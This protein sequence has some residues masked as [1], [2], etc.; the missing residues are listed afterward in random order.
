MINLGL[1]SDQNVYY[2]PKPNILEAELV[3][4]ILV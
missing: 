1:K 2:M 3:Y 4:I